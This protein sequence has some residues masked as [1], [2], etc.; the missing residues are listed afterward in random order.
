[1]ENPVKP[2]PCRIVGAIVMSI[3]QGRGLRFSRKDRTFEVNK[4]FIT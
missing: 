3:R 2:R 1:M 4:L